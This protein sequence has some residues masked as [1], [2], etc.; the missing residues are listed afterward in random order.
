MTETLLRISWRVMPPSRF[1]WR[2]A[3]RS[4]SSAFMRSVMSRRIPDIPTTFPDA[5]VIAVP[6]SSNQCVVPVLSLTLKTVLVGFPVETV[7][8]KSAITTGRSSS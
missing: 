8:S 6:L 1:S 4:A 7:F 5:S 2:F 3:C